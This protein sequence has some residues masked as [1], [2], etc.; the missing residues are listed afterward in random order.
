M[1]LLVCEIA[2]KK[3]GSEAINPSQQNWKL[4][5][6]VEGSIYCLELYRSRYKLLDATGVT[7]MSNDGDLNNMWNEATQDIANIDP[8]KTAS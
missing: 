3:A 1:K 6:L 8:G 7:N 4:V 2:V 5:R